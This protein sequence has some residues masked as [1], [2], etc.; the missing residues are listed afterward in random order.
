MEYDFHKW[1]IDRTR[2]QTQPPGVLQSIGD[3]AA[4]LGPD[5]RLT[6]I[7]SDSIAD[8]THFLLAKH[9]LE[10]I[11]YK[12]VAVN[13]SDVCAMGAIPAF[14]VV[15]LQLP[16]SFGLAETQ[17]LYLGIENATR[18]NGMSV[19][20]GDTNRWSGSLVISITVIGHLTNGQT[21]WL[22]TNAKTGDQI[23]VT[24]SFGGSIH[25]RHL[26]P[27][28]RVSMIKQLSEFQINAATDVSDSLSLDLQSI[29]SASKIGFEL[30]V[31]AIPVSAD[32]PA[33]DAWKRIEHALYDGEDFELI[34]LVSQKQAE[35][36][37]A[38]PV[39][40]QL[41][42]IGEATDEYPEIRIQWKSQWEVLSPKGFV[43]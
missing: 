19:V 29:A 40:E 39:G 15:N 7:S 31:Q 18:S 9:S 30:D 10:D 8:G 28:S 32:V 41:T 37:L 22:K 12:S 38:S 4:V 5:N 17:E 23:L 42:R 27:T 3:D 36:V 25:G 34:L 33:D 2:S 1:L 16:L 43:H 35:Q 6:V 20:G 11:G 21:P 26:R 24:G 13:I 14:A